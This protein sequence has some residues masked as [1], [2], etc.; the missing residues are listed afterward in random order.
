M[1]QSKYPNK[2]LFGN[3]TEKEGTL[4]ALDDENVDFGIKMTNA[5]DVQ[6]ID[7]NLYMSKELWLPYG[8]RGAFG[9]QIVAQALNAGF[10]TIPEEFFIHSLHAYF[11]LACN[12]E[13]PVIYKVRR[14]RDGRSYATRIITATQR[15]KAIFVC[16]CSFAKPDN[17]I[18]LD[19]QSNMPDVTDPDSLPSDIEVL[20]STLES[21][22][23]PQKF[24][25]Q[26]LNRLQDDQPVDYREVIS[27]TSEEIATGNVKPNAYNQRWF[28]TRGKL[29]DDLRLHAC[30]IAYASDSGFVNTAAKANGLTFNSEGVGMMTS[31]DHTIWFHQPARADEWLLYDMHSPRTSG[32]RGVAFGR[33]YTRDGRLVATTAQE[34]IVRLSELEQERRKKQALGEQDIKSNQGEN[35][36]L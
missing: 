7:T 31:L 26:L 1:S 23:Y 33:I 16:S 13:I 10:Q 6:M 20:Q 22:D 2:I 30:I 25:K 17:S 14:V 15:G 21:T 35:S 11:I 12:V 29:G 5:I 19:H 36:R 28:K 24:R 32:G 27:Y 3:N 8:S 18:H 4:V 9:G 34:G